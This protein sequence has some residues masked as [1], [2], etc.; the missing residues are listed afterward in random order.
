M[1]LYRLLLMLAPPATSDMD[2]YL[3][4]RTE[5]RLSWSLIRVA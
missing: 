5:A 3:L 1:A 2:R 4:P